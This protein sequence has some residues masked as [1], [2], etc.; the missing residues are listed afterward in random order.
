LVAAAF[1]AAVIWPVVLVCGAGITVIGQGA[2]G[3]DPLGFLG[4]LQR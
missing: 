4:G 1:I 2:D 3:I